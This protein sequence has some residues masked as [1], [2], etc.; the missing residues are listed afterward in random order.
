M[1][2]T[3]NIIKVQQGYAV[4]RSDTTMLNIEIQLVQKLNFNLIKQLKTLI[5]ITST[6]N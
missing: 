6:R 3:S 4:Q 1:D 2:F 5:T